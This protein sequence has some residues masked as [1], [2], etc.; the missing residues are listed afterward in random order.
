MGIYE[1]LGVRKLINCMGPVTK[2]GGSLMPEE[3]F[4]AIQEAAKSFVSIEELLEKSGD[5]IAN[6]IGVP[7]AF[8][9]SG[10]AAGL[11]VS[12]AA[13]MTGNDI[14]K[15]KQLPN[16]HKMKNEVIIHHCHRIDYDQAIRLA[17]A[18]FVEIEPS[19]CLN[20]NNLK[21]LINSKTAAIFYVAKFEKIKGSIPIK[22]VIKIAKNTGIPVIVD[23][24]DELPPLSNLTKYIN[25]GAE[26]VIFSGGKD[27]RG[28]Q[29]SGLILGTKEFIKACSINGSPNYSIGRPMKVSKEEIVGL[30][31]AIE[32]YV[33]KDFNLDIKRSKK[34][35]QYI[36]KRISSIPNIHCNIDKTL[37]A[38]TPGSF[39]LPSIYID[40]DEASLSATKDEIV[41]KLWDGDPRIAVDQSLDGIVL[42]MMMLEVGQ[43]KLVADRLLE[44]FQ[45]QFYR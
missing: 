37:Q 1:E 11:A 4:S 31:K 28:P 12:I 23:A 18:K 35:Q 22:K 43:E 17:G 27:L 33:N 21:T 13:C 41:K 40:F 45:E 20:E 10:A 44:I 26:L 8:I 24:A 16:T 36:M 5:R 42:R 7:A 14:M 29:G 19:D 38:G 3:V 2:I 39:Y 6:L 15:A 34:Q 9:T 30:T 32:L 25:M